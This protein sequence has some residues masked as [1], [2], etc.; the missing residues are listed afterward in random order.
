MVQEKVEARAG[1]RER[2]ERETAVREEHGR[3]VA[4]AAAKFHTVQQQI[5]RRASY[6]FASA[7]L[8]SSEHPP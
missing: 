4:R 2:Q 5:D 8:E 6:A 3:R 1:E 7:F